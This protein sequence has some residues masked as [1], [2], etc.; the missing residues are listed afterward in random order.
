MLE[1]PS[2]TAYGKR[3]ALARNFR[4][5]KQHELSKMTGISQPTIGSAEAQ[6][7]GSVH[8]AQLAKALNVDAYWLATGHGHMLPTTTWPFETFTPS[9]IST[10]SKEA[11]VY[12]EQMVTNALLYL[13]SGDQ[14]I[15]LVDIPPLKKTGQDALGNVHSNVKEISGLVD[16]QYF[17]ASDTLGDISQPGNRI[18]DDPSSQK[19]A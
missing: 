14:K 3:L 12:I 13:L 17:F 19:K 1:K 16:E 18:P 7:R 8:T 9:D 4:G 5:I 15:Q 2:Q 6:G 11:R 10:I